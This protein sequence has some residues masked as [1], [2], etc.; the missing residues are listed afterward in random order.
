MKLD[1]IKGRVRKALED[2]SDTKD[3]D[4][5]LL[6]KIW[7]ADLSYLDYNVKT[8]SVEKFLSDFKERKLTHP[9]TVR[10]VRQHLQEHDPSL[11]GERYE[12]RHTTEV[13]RTL[14]DLG[15]Q[16]LNLFE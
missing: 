7:E 5:L 12:E 9:E 11:R 16:Q 4:Y 15:Y 1:Y 3:C 6:A 2:H 10:R 13:R 14:E 8:D